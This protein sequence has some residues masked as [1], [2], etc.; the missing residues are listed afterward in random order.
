M[1]Q[2][3]TGNGG[4]PSRIGRIN[5]SLM[6]LEFIMNCESHKRTPLQKHICHFLSKMLSFC[7]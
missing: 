1:I 3:H 7:H 5:D 2:V 4:S 6:S